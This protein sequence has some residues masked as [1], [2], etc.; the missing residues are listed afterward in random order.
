VLDPCTIDD[1]WFGFDFTTFRIVPGPG[2]PAVVEAGV[3]ST[4]ARL[5]LNL[6]NDYVGERIS[7]IRDYSLDRVPFA[8]VESKYPFLA[9]QIR[10]QDFDLRF[11]GRFAAF[12]GGRAPP[13]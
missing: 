5:E 4:I 7:V 1:G 9:R 2:L 11:K 10:I 6:D 8:A 13:R 3:T 12:F